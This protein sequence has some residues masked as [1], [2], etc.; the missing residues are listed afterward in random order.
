MFLPD[1]KFGSGKSSHTITAKLE[2]VCI[3]KKI[4]H[5]NFPKVAKQNGLKIFLKVLKEIVTAK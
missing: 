2:G 5:N 3:K 4:K 1:Y